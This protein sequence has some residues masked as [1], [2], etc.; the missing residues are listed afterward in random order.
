MDEHSNIADM[1][2]DRV[3]WSSLEEVYTVV[4]RK[5]A[6]RKEGKENKQSKR[7]IISVRENV[8]SL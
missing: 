5:V 1:V 6:Q 2:I 7:V 8:S 4:R 3:T